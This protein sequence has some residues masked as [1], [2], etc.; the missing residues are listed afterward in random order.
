MT[1]GK[2][3]EAGIFNCFQLFG[4]FLSLYEE[5]R[6]IP[7]CCAA[8]LCRRHRCSCA[9]FDLFLFAL[10]SLPYTLPPPPLLQAHMNAFVSWLKSV[11]I[12]AHRNTIAEAVA[13][14]AA[15]WD[16][17]LYRSDLFDRGSE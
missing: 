3:K 1:A 2:L 16:S 17:Q 4:K 7:V 11:G 9:D 10:T 12:T 5:G 13:E 15:A 6:D 8:A 14:K